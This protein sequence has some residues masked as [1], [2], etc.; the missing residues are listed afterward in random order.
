MALKISTSIRL[1]GFGNRDKRILTLKSPIITIS[2]SR[3]NGCIFVAWINKENSN[4]Q[5]KN[6]RIDLVI[7]WITNLCNIGETMSLGS[8]NDFIYL[9][10]FIFFVFSFSFIHSILS[11]FKDSFLVTRANRMTPLVLT[12]SQDFNGLIKSVPFLYNT[13]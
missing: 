12:L 2:K 6:F 4:N 1:A 8:I 7:S 9:F 11:T 5:V 3:F 10:S 13:G